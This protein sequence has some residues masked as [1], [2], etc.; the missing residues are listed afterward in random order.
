MIFRVLGVLLI[1][2]TLSCSAVKEMQ[3]ND[4]INFLDK[5]FEKLFEKRLISQR[6]VSYILRFQK[7]K[8]LSLVIKV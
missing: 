1:M 3:P 5:N 8:I 4:V 7:L 2:L 6:E